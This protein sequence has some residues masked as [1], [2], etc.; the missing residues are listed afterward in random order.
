M[1]YSSM[2]SCRCCLARDTSP[3]L[4]EWSRSNQ[5]EGPHVHAEVA[6]S[7]WRIGGLAD[8]DGTRHESDRRYMLHVHAPAWPAHVCLHLL[9]SSS[10][11]HCSD[12]FMF[13]L[14]I[15]I[16]S[17]MSFILCSSWFP[18]RQVALLSKFLRCPADSI[19]TALCGDISCKIC[20][21]RQGVLHWLRTMICPLS[22][23]L[24]R[25]CG[26]L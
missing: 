12:M 18:S 5:I 10:Q 9:T 8:W 17:S 3:L 26:N 14:T 2:G 11:W 13:M 1:T 7:Y 6:I 4:V 15:R 22:P 19:G 23:R 20:T 16:E 24:P 21:C 25:P